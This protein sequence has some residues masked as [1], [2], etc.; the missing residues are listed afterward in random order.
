MYAPI[1]HYLANS[2][3]ERQRVI[4]GQAKILVRRGQI[5]RAIDPV[6]EQKNSQ[7]HFVIDIAR[8][9]NQ[10]P[11]RAEK[12]ISC[13]PGASV[14]K[15]DL[16][17]GPIGITRRVVRSPETGRV[18]DV[19]RGKVLLELAVRPEK[20][21]AGLSGKV[22]EL[23]SE[24]GVVIQ[25]SGALVQAGWG[26]GKIGEGILKVLS[27]GKNQ[28]LTLE[29]LDTSCSGMILVVD[30]CQDLKALEMA[31]NLSVQGLVMAG[32]NPNLAMAAINVDIPIIL[33]EGFGVR[34]LNSI[35]REILEDNDG[36]LASLNAECRQKN[37]AYRPELVIPKEATTQYKKPLSQDVLAPGKDVRLVGP[38]SLGRSG[39]LVDLVG[40]IVMPG[41]YRAS[42]A[43]ILYSD[44]QREIVPIRNLELLAR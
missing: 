38:S 23:I 31:I 34:I 5:V 33:I 1:T 2:I 43:S 12:L 15:G 17:A 27:N 7:K 30:Y 16:L 26:N 39:K 35:A 9:L 8:G 40:E 42:A 14:T 41:G 28:E 20:M 10:S 18:A 4:Q 29:M 13:K 21:L 6:L 36:I 37:P 11:E 3:I 19:W 25:S 44:G 22:S 32:M 24:N